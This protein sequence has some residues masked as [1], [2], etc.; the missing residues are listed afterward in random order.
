MIRLQSTFPVL[1][2]TTSC[3]NQAEL[4]N[5][6]QVCP[7][8]TALPVP[9]A[10]F[11]CLE[12]FPLCFSSITDALFCLSS[13]STLCLKSISHHY[14]NS[15]GIFYRNRKNNSKICTKPQEALNSQSNLE[16][17]TRGITFP[18]NYI[19]KLKKSK[20]YKTVTE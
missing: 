18:S 4:L 11:L 10:V 3:C 14:Q 20:Q 2:S 17:K 9:L 5:V 8:S 16:I 19:T 6:S 15:N 12:H 1:F 7:H 13:H